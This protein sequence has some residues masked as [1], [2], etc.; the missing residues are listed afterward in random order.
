[1]ADQSN[2]TTPSDSNSVETNASAHA[3]TLVVQELS[4]HLRHMEVHLSTLSNLARVA[5]KAQTR[6]MN[7]IERDVDSLLPMI[8]KGRTSALKHLPAEAE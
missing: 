2:T 5:V 3:S 4:A 1:M 8:Q 6:T 7:M